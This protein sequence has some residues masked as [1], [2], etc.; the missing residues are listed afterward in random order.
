MTN[1]YN[2]E[3]TLFDTIFWIDYFYFDEN[4][5]LISVYMDM[6]NDYALDISNMLF[7]PLKK[8]IFDTLYKKNFSY[9]HKTGTITYFPKHFIKEGKI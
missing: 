6:E 1:L 8:A 3:L 2:A 7:N 4:I 5:Y 9:S